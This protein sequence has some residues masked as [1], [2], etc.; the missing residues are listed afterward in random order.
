MVAVSV[1]MPVYNSSKFLNK[2]IDSIQKQ[3]LKDIEIICVDD[4]STDDS[5]DILNDLKNKYDNIKIICQQ[6]SGPGV[7][8]NTGIKNAKGEYVAFLDS[9]DIY[10]DGTALEQ[11]YNL[12]KSN[13]FN[14]ICTNLKRINQDYTIDINYDFVN[15]RFTY[16]YKHDI[17]K[18]EDYGIPFAFYRNLF[19]RSFL[20][21]N[22][23]EFPDL[24]FGEDPVFMVN[25]LVNINEFLA[26]PIDFYGYNHSIGGG[27]NEKITDF[28]KKNAYIKH[29]K[30]I[31]DILKINNLDS[32]F[33]IYKIE[34][35]D[36]LIYSDNI[37]DNQIKNIIKVL[38]KN[39]KE[40]FDEN[41]YGF[42]IMDF[43]IN[44]D[45]LTN[46]ALDDS[47][48]LNFHENEFHEY[49]EIKKY[50]FEET[51]VN[52]NFID[53]VRLRDY[54]N[55]ITKNN[56]K[57]PS[58]DLKEYSFNELIKINRYISQNKE[59]LDEETN[60]L[61][62]E[63]NSSYF[64]ENAEFLRK[65]LESR[66]D[67]KNYG[68]ETNNVIILQS[69][70][71]SLNIKQPDWFKDE[72]GIGT[73]VSSVNGD[74]NLS[75]E[76]VNDGILELGFKAIDFRDKN[77]NRIP[78]YIDYTEIIVNDEFI[79]DESRVSWHDNPFIF[80]KEVKNGDIID[81]KAKWEPINNKSN[82]FLPTDYDK[83]IEK[84]Y[85]VRVDLKNNGKEDN[86]LILVHC[87]DDFSDIYKP[88]WFKNKEGIGTVV[89]SKKGNM[90]MSFK[91]INDGDLE[92]DFRSNR[93]RYK[94]NNIP[95]FL[96]FTKIRI[97]GKNVI[98]D[99]FISWY[100][101]PFVYKQ[102][103]KNNQ[104]I[105]IDLEWKPVDYESNMHLLHD[106]NY[107]DLNIYSQARFD[108]K[109]YGET[110]N[111]IVLINANTSFYN[112]DK[113]EWFSDSKGIGSTITSLNKEL[114]L[115]FKCINDGKLKIE[116]KGIDYR[117][118]NNDRI[119]IYIDYKKIEIDGKS[120]ID[121]STVLWHDNGLSF[122]KDVKDGQI[123]NIELKWEP[124]N[125]NSNCRN[126]LFDSKDE[127]IE[128]LK[129][130]LKELTNE[131]I[132]LKKFKEELLNSNSWKMMDSLRKI[133]NG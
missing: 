4:G 47:Y 123:V 6:N 74:L 13:D 126:L 113:P 93:L 44:E 118:R 5:L 39:Y 99:S 16:F 73:I 107:D 116:F 82:I 25:V 40:Y 128:K 63:L 87:D 86:N 120:I 51:S 24:R 119:P 11:M 84:F 12:G 66:I 94:N 7:A 67:I 42:F 21:E 133:R 29:F 54:L 131:N 60:N 85:E 68:N 76:C 97:N 32:I 2:S 124:L 38:F 100:D 52:A 92:I 65:Y 49:L 27:V 15:S 129:G 26:L 90:S 57:N 45:Q 114:N 105:N 18:S 130:E 1:I 102:K 91:C 62:N 14:L 37:H 132:E 98:K 17:L 3:S 77:E 31:F 122:D 19:K 28:A 59:S 117:D 35:I 111:D 46:K 109:N 34:F 79:V 80:K 127:E 56:Y 58:M 101:K 8:R 125:E 53:T 115:S 36:Y 78:V 106:N 108:I 72:E 30:D 88:F 20:V 95:I 41:D 121:G 104:I 75:F 48:N 10:L 70:D 96:D 64:D 89:F 33:S 103:V 71:S 69:N 112:M 61:E 22:G 55:Y 50:L 83:V 81:I 110:N 43:I 23:I 9:D